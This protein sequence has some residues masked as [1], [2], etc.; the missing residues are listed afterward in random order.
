MSQVFQ[1][2][3]PK[4]YQRIFLDPLG[5][6]RHNSLVLYLL[7]LYCALFLGGLWL[8]DGNFALATG[9]LLL[10]T[11]VLVT[12]SK[13]DYGF[14]LFILLVL[15][16]DQYHIP[17]FEP[18]TYTIHF[19]N[20]LKEIPYIPFFNA[21]VVNPVELLLIL[22]IL[23]VLTYTVVFK[24]FKLQPIAVWGAF[25]IFFAFYAFS[26]VYGIY[27]GGDFLVAMWEV[28]ALFYFFLVYLLVPQ[29]I[30]N[31]E[32][33]NL[34]I[35]VFIIGISFKAIQG[36]GRFVAMGF[37]TGGLDTLT[38]HEDPVFM[39]TLF[40]LL[41]G[42]IAFNVKNKQKLWLLILVPVFLLGFYVALRRAAYASFMVSFA[43]FIVLLPGLIR[44]KF[45]KSAL[46]FLIGI[47]IYGA[48]FWNYGSEHNPV[49]RPVQMI[50]AGFE[51]PTLEENARDYYSNL[52]RE[53]ENYNLAATVVNN[54][55]KGVGFGKKYEQPIP[56]VDIHFPLRDYIP[57]NEIFWVL[58]KMGGVGFLAFWFFF[59]CFVARGTKV[60]LRL[61]DPYL[62][63]ISVFIIIAVINQM[64]VSYFDLQLTY[65][66]NMIYLGCIM[67]L[68]PVVEKFGNEY[69]AQQEAAKNEQ[70]K[71]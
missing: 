67:G 45:L 59:N 37:S 23:S 46:P 14:Y 33:L 41:F 8:T 4:F 32:Q 11:I 54:P 18:A 10:I 71:E 66:R 35:W 56:L 47:L 24:D 3:I 1:Q 48:I 2:F 22:I 62:K 25:L 49:A 19:F 28:R 43:T 61:E 70:E 50:K 20:N 36:I 31:R 21:G 51:R 53:Q 6:N 40:I 30:R 60:M 13:P 26:F 44:W 38:N 65:Y 17:G 29:I 63:A 69:K 64:V 5:L 9:L 57:H 55:V 15:I 16:F 68:L 52:Y 34:L 12:F 42:F 7:L 27:A 39:V 58:V